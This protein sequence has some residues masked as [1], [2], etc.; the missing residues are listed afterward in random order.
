MGFLWWFSLFRGTGHGIIAAACKA[1][2]IER[3]EPVRYHPAR[4]DGSE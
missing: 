3:G 1:W 2:L 4:K